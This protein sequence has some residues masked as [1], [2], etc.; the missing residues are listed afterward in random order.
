[1]SEAEAIAYFCAE[2]SAHARTLPMRDATLFLRGALILIGAESDAVSELRSAFMRLS[3]ADAQLEL[4]A[5]PQ[6]KLPLKGDG[7][8]KKGQP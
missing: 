1:M 7:N 4:I 2:M 8:G 6:L 3:A 5:S